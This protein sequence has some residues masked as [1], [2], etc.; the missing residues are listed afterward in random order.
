MNVGV[1]K[2]R[3]T[4]R[5]PLRHPR[6]SIWYFS[7]CIA[8]SW[9]CSASWALIYRFAGPLSRLRIIVCPGTRNPFVP[10]NLPGGDFASHPHLYLPH[11]HTCVCVYVKSLICFIFLHFILTQLYFLPFLFHSAQTGRIRRSFE[12]SIVQKVF[13]N[14]IC[15][16]KI[17]FQQK[18]SAFYFLPPNE[19]DLVFLKF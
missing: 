11:L 18:A 6:H 12:L 2:E 7:L 17:F 8:N 15:R 14:L 4:F 19:F 3:S 13:K 10:V 16:Q 5:G 1:F 9:N